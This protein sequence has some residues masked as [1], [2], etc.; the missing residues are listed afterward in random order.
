MAVN[1][2]GYTTEMLQIEKIKK[3][4]KEIENHCKFL[5]EGKENLEVKEIKFTDN[6]TEITINTSFLIDIKNKLKDIDLIFNKLKNL[7]M[8]IKFQEQYN[9][10]KISQINN[11]IDDKISNK[12]F[13][14]ILIN[15]FDNIN[16]KVIKNVIQLLYNKGVFD[17]SINKDQVWE[18]YLNFND[19]YLIK[20]YGKEIKIDKNI[21]YLSDLNYNT[22]KDII[23]Q[24]KT[25]KYTDIVD[26]RHRMKLTEDEIKYIIF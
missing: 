25:N 2:L 8:I 7:D 17:D 12:V 24:L 19:D 21:Y 9:K 6:Q 4:E 1:K 22:R 20:K 16:E 10:E 14:E 23:E 5:Q 26:M 11:L 18:P 15:E 3:L 13:E